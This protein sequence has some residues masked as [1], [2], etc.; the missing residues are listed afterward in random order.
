MI[1]MI[2]G[3]GI[4]G[5]GVWLFSSPDSEPTNTEAAIAAT[6]AVTRA[7]EL[8]NTPTPQTIASETV[9][10]APTHT[11]VP[12]TAPPRPVPSKIITIDNASR[13]TEL[14]RLGRGTIEDIALS[15][16]D[17]TLT[18]G[19]SQGI[20]LYDARSLI[21]NRLLAGHTIR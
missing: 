7:A 6:I 15:P 17:N 18:V 1:V 13:I 3:A 5:A 8:D 10:P 11:P 12:P 14:Q 9:A 19:G 2:L 21:L 4:L 20:W 16:D